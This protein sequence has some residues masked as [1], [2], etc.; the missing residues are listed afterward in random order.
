MF[1]YKFKEINE[2][3]QK[4]NVKKKNRTIRRVN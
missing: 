2:M 1:I 3:N 4:S